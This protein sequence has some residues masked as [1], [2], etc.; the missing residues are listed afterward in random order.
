MI[1]DDQTRLWLAIRTTHQLISGQDVEQS[2]EFDSVRKF[3]DYVFLHEIRTEVVDP[4]GVVVFV[5]LR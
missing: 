2:E 3:S 1:K 4:S 5:L